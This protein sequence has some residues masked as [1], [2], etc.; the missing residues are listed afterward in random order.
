[1]ALR[2]W[3]PLNG[4]LENQGLS[5][6]TP[7]NHNCTIANGK[8]GQ[9]YSFDGSTSYIDIGSACNEI[10]KGYGQPFTLAF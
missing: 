6:L 4:T 8:I 1:M 7:V 9:C 3:L 2:V 10:I 5:E